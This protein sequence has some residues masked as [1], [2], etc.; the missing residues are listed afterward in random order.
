M[1]T[2]EQIRGARA[3]LGLTQAELAALA[4]LSTTGL[5]N[6]ERGLADPKASTLRA[7]QTALEAKSVIFLGDGQSAD[8]GP[9]IRLRRA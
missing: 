9:G 8:G 6:I 1:I 4:G 7:I 2:P 3:M 5:N